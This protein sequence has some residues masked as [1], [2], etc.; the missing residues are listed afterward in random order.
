MSKTNRNHFKKTIALLF[1]ISIGVIG[2]A[3]TNNSNNKTALRDASL[4]NKLDL[5]DWKLEIAVD[6]D[7]NGK[8]DSIYPPKL[9]NYKHP[10]FFYY[11]DDGG[12]VFRAPMYG[13]T[14]SKNT[15]FVRTELR[16]LLRRDNKKI[17]LT[18][19]SKNNWVFSS[20]S[21]EDQKAAAGVDGMLNVT[22]KVDRVSS[23]GDKNQEGRIII[24]QIH[25]KKDEPVRIYYRKLK[26]NK[27]GSIYIAHEIN[28][29]GKTLWI[30]LIGSKSSN[31]ADPADGIALGEVF[32]YQIK[33]LAHLLSVTIFREGKPNV[34]KTIDMVNSG[35]HNKPDEYMYFKAG[36]YHAV[37]TGEKGDYAQAT[38]YRI[39][40][41]HVGYNW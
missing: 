5:G 16:E 23:T 22:L 10:K 17:K 29:T 41:K 24:G 35:Y 27:K 15:K 11:A 13:I 33:V 20:Y 7:G 2:C 18:G 12:L 37:N 21:K 32:S 25:A 39:E 28:R 6:E 9:Q 31:A 1:V 40:N 30:D 14:T 34:V 19:I 26:D 4:N 3:G 8:S 38:F 36:I